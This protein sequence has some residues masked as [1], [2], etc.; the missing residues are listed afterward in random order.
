MKLYLKRQL[1]KFKYRNKCIFDSGTIIS[2]N[3]IFEGMNKIGKN[4]HFDG[5]LGYGSYISA[6][7][8]IAMTEVGKFTSIGPRVVVNPGRHPYTYPYVTTC[9]AFYSIRKQNSGTFVDSTKYDEFNFV[10]PGFVV[11]IGSDK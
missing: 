2:K 4:T 1:L 8:D 7:C 10:K 3:T 9:P 5:K 11:K 6:H